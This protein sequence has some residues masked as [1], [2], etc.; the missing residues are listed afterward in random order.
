MKHAAIDA[1]TSAVNVALRRGAWIETP[2]GSSVEKKFGVALR[3][4]AWIETSRL[5]HAVSESLVAL[6]R[7]AWIETAISQQTSGVV[8]S[9]APQGRVD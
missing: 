2:I 1:L 3:R 8:L 4:G 5:R 6:R 7:G 9:R